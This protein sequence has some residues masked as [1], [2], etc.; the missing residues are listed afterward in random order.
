MVVLEV[1]KIV[2]TKQLA[3]SA[4]VPDATSVEVPDAPKH[5]V[6]SA[7]VPDATSVEVPDAI[8]VEEPLR[9]KRY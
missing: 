2:A 9:D 7:E 3:V 6:V 8:S 5:L 1:E 4:E